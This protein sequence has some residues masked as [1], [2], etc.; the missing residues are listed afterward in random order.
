MVEAGLMPTQPNITAVKTLAIVQLELDK[1]L[2]V[3][4]AEGHYHERCLNKLLQ[5][6]DAL[7]SYHTL[8]KQIFCRSDIFCPCKATI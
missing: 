2:Q 5:S 4:L 3:L 6:L 8:F 1:V 7:L